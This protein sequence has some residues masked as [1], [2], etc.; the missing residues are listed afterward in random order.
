M[1]ISGGNE[2]AITLSGDA[3]IYLTSASDDGE[4][5]NLILSCAGTTVAE[6]SLSPYSADA[7]IAVKAY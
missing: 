2:L 5:G 3:A 1:D 7:I 4:F 6:S